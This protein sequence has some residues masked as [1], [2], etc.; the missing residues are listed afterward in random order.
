MKK[1]SRLVIK[2]Y[3]VT[4]VSNGFIP[5]VYN[6]LNDL[7][8]EYLKNIDE[9]WFFKNCIQE[10]LPFGNKKINP[11][12]TNVGNADIDANLKIFLCQLNNLSEKENLDI[13]NLPNCKYKDISYFSNLEVELKSKCLS[14]FHLNISSLPKSFDNFN[15]LINKLKLE[16]NILG[17]SE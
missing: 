11:N 12:I 14:F 3:V 10:I 16:F 2:Q 4:Y 15:H 13:E 6:S 7:D 9:T 1:L 8:D 5:D 17:I